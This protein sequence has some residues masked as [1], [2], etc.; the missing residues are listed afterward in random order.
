MSSFDMTRRFHVAMKLPV[1]GK[2]RVPTIDER[3][4]R[5]QLLL[6]ET[7]ETITQGLGIT[8]VLSEGP[9][10]SPGEAVELADLVFIVSHPYDPIET[11]DGLADVKVI[12]NGTAVQ[13]GL[14][15]EAADRLVFGS[16]MSK[17]DDD[18]NPIINEC[19]VVR[20]D[21]VHDCEEH[22]DKCV[23]R[24]PSQPAGKIL[25]SK[26]FKKPNI[27]GLLESVCLGHTAITSRAHDFKICGKC[28]V[29]IDELR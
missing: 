19:V 1:S 23:F 27:A 13:F 10:L 26:K 17:L 20:V 3:V 5:A 29:H 8:F 7:L 6:E 9:T 18:G 21:P 14:P 25:K 4:L 24:D 16:N 28:G 22:A 2:L 15:M 11:L 12:A